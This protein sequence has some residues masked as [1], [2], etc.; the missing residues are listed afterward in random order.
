MY[1]DDSGSR[2]N[3]GHVRNSTIVAAR[4]AVATYA[5]RLDKDKEKG[6]CKWGLWPDVD[7][8]ASYRRQPPDRPRLD[9]KEIIMSPLEYRSQ[10]VRL[11]NPGWATARRFLGRP[12]ASFFAVIHSAT[13]IASAIAYSHARVGEKSASGSHVL[14]ALLGGRFRFHTVRFFQPLEGRVG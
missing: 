12:P 11:K 2:A 4:A 8:F 1:A 10:T 14:G 3:L 9:S 13:A 7:I 5:S 6:P